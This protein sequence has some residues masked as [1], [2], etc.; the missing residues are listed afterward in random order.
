MDRNTII[1]MF[2]ALDKTPSEIDRKLHLEE[3]T[4]HD[5]IVKHWKDDSEAFKRERELMLYGLESL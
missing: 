3:G 1:H 4:A 5:V 2:Y